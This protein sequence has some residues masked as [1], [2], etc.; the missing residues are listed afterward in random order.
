MYVTRGLL[1]NAGSAVGSQSAPPLDL[2]YLP[3]HPLLG[4]VGSPRREGEVRR[5]TQH[6]SA[7]VRAQ[8]GT[9]T[10]THAANTSTPTSFLR[11]LVYG[12][13]CSNAIATQ[14]SNGRVFTEGPE[15]TG[16]ELRALSG[17]ISSLCLFRNETM[18]GRLM[19]LCYRLRF[20]CWKAHGK[21]ASH[22]PSVL[23]ST[24]RSTM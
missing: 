18:T 22:V 19:T 1:S 11:N 21:K 12:E 5:R 15:Q 6:Q 2:F 4:V 3:S 14:A 23:T 7:A 16:G 9:H 17:A 10:H 24:C 8:R 13:I 20:C